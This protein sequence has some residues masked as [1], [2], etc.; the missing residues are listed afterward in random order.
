MA[1]SRLVHQQGA[2][3][4]AHPTETNAWAVLA[5]AVLARQAETNAW[6]VLARQAALQP[7]SKTLSK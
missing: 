1:H 7:R 2:L 4:H 5:W 3:L 6:A